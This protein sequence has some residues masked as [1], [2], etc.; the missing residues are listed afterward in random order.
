LQEIARLKKKR[1]RFSVG[2]S[3]GHLEHLLGGELPGDDEVIK[4]ISNRHFSV[5]SLITYIARHT[6]INELYVSTFGVGRKEIVLLEGLRQQGKL[7]RASFVA[8]RIMANAADKRERDRLLRQICE[9]NEWRYVCI[10]NHAK[11]TLFDTDAG[12]FVI[13]TSSNLNENPSIEHFSFERSE[14]GY[15]FY[16]EWFESWLN[17]KQSDGE[18]RK[19]C[20]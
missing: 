18:N 19:D 1:T 3:V 12:K 10:D 2:G 14:D 16:R 9:Q 7:K 8:G 13:E 15:D 20:C 5:I 11:L 17:Q 6:P 4:L